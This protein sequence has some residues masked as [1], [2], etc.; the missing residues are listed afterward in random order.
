MTVI[1][2]VKTWLSGYEGLEENAPLWVDHIDGATPGG[3]AIF[4][5]PGNKIIEEYLDGGSLREFPFAFQSQELTT[6]ELERLDNLGFFEAFSD[7]LETQTNSDDMPDL[8][9][10]KTAIKIET[11]N[12]AFLYKEGE[13][14]TGIYMIQCRLEYEQQPLGE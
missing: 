9:E 5:V 14:N 3:Y 4:S 1:E 13:S 12:W 2:S 10:G 7:W 11:T 6:D 8:G